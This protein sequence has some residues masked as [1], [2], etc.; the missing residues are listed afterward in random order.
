MPEEETD[1]QK[2]GR[3]K[4]RKAPGMNVFTVDANALDVQRGCEALNAN[5]FVR[6]VVP[7]DGVVIVTYGVY[8]FEQAK[9]AVRRN[10]RPTKTSLRRICLSRLI[11]R[12]EVRLHL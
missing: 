5:G 6:A 7:Q 11:L 9:Q 2:L 3:L 12:S 4:M 1:A 10:S 8:P